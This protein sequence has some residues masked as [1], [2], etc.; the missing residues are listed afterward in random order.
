MGTD[1]EY[2]AQR[3]MKEEMRAAAAGER[4]IGPLR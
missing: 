2:F 4:L 3:A 1:R